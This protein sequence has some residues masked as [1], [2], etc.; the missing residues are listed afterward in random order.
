MS[1][2]KKADVK[3]H[4]SRKTRGTLLLFKSRSQPDA[5][6]YSGNAGPVSE[7]NTPNSGTPS[8]SKHPL[9]GRGYSISIDG[10]GHE[11]LV[12]ASADEKAQA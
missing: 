7:Q 4:V 6:G 10:S 5:T 11:R 8:G 9:P 12:E 3:P 1:V 2:I